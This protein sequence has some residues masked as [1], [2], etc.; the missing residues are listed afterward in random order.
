MSLDKNWLRGRIREVLTKHDVFS[1]EAVE[2]L[3]LTA[4]QES[5]LGTYLTQ[6][7]GPALSIFQVEP[8]TYSD[9]YKRVLNRRWP[10]RFSPDPM[11]MIYDFD[12]SIMACRGKYLSIP[13]AIPK[14]LIPMAQYWK[15]YYNTALGSGRP[16]DAI[17]N[18][19]KYC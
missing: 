9:I 4:A 8:K 12:V 15:T 18:Y 13:I 6:V 17:R 5:L 16:G 10:G 14:Q 3:M 1:V 11:S 19:K 2:L 7:E